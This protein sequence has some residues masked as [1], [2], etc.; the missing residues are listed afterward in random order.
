MILL[1]ETYVTR[2]WIESVVVYQ[3]LNLQRFSALFLCN[4]C[5]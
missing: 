2:G 4:I 3:V 5:G 1:C